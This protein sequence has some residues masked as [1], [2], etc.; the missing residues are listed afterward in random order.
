MEI[1][2]FLRA[3]LFISVLLSC[4]FTL[5]TGSEM[6]FVTCGSVVKLL[7][8]KHNVRLHSHDVRYGSGSGQQSV[9]GVTAVED[10]NSYWS[11][12]GTSDT[13]CHRG[14]PVQCG[15][16]IRLTHV[17]TGRN[18]HSHYFTSPLSSNQ[19]VS[20]FGENGE[21]DHLDE[22]TV[23]CAGSVWKRDDSVRFRHTATDALLSV[24]GE[25]Y[26]RPIHGQ[27]EVHG[28]MISGS[29]SDWKT[30]EGIFMKPSETGSRDFSSPIHTEF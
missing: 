12:R 1:S 7:N 8:V 9:T 10:S 13:A 30:M 4:M 26:G 3:Q 17:N 6:S 21:G 2:R 16:N 28:M 23:L 27:R 19:E 18:L 15:Q 5:S 24:T 14:N 20:A 11:V 22:W 29:H 25:Q